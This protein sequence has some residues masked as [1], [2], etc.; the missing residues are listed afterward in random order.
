MLRT[1]SPSVTLWEAILPERF[2]EQPVELGLV[3]KILDDPVFFEPFRAYFNATAGRPSTPIDTYL[4][5]MYLKHRYGLGYERLCAMVA[6]SITLCR[7]CRISLGERVPEP[8]TIRKITKRCGPELVDEL[9]EKLL[10]K[11][12]AAQVVDLAQVRADSTVVEADVKYPTDSGLLTKAIGR[13]V[14]LVERIQATGAATRTSVVD[15]TATARTKAH[16]VAMT[17]RTR[18]G[19]AKEDVLGITG[20]LAVLAEET[21]KD[22]ARVIANA[23][24]FLAAHPEISKAGRLRAMIDDLDVLADRTHTVIGQARL[25]IGGGT[26]AG[27]SRLVSLHDPDARPIVKGRLG[28]RSCEFGYKAQIVDNADGL[29]LDHSTHVGN[30][31]DTDLIVGAIERLKKRFGAAPGEFTADRGYHSTKV[32]AKLAELGVGYTAIPATGKPSAA[33]RTEQQTDQFMRLVKWR[34][35]SEGRISTLKREYG[36]RRTRVASIRG[37]TT[38]IG[39]SVLAHNLTKSTHLLAASSP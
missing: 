13:M 15:H 1:V 11:L 24:R 30:P 6:D 19:D 29:V 39:L 32:N 33:R 3:D 12:A 23:R 27:A 5:M 16:E 7:F 18:S 38:W 22:C 4:R 17:L 37:A 21:A 26:P 20:D 14:R 35:G 9:N 8:S 31:A 25:R 2:R 10:A 34:T 28:A 36:M